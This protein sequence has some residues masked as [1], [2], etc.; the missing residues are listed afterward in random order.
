MTKCLQTGCE[1]ISTEHRGNVCPN[2]DIVLPS[3]APP[4]PQTHPRVPTF[5]PPRKAQLKVWFKEGLQTYTKPLLWSLLSGSHAH[6][7]LHPM[8]QSRSIPRLLA[9][10]TKARWGWGPPAW[11]STGASRARGAP[12]LPP[13]AAIGGEVA[14]HPLPTTQDQDIGF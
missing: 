6:V 14:S 8:F 11:P 7:V 12:W 3:L 2:T 10:S 9:G 4:S 13:A 1:S 5:I